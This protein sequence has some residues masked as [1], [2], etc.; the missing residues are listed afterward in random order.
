MG[1]NGLKAH[2]LLALVIMGALIWYALDLRRLAA[3]GEDRPARLTGVSAAV[4]A[5]LFV[6]LLYGAWVAG[7]DAGLVALYER[8]RGQL[9]GSGAAAL[10]GSRCEGCRLELN[11]LDLEQI[12]ARPVDAVV[13]CEE[14]GRILVRTDA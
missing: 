4:L 8:L 11:P 10:R 1:V 2:L 12:R 13:R 14:C 5:V 3:T 6:Q 7:L 9:G